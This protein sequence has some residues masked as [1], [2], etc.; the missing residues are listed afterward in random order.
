MSFSHYDEDGART[1]HRTHCCIGARRATHCATGDDNNAFQFRLVL[2]SG[3]NGQVCYECD[4]SPHD[5]VLVDGATCQAC[6]DHCD[7]CEVVG[8]QVHCMNDNCDDQ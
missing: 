1:S 6:V 7:K 3:Y 8:G 4:E 5:W 2:Q